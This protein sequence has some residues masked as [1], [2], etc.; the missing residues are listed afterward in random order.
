M[1]KKKLSDKKLW[2][3]YKLKEYVQDKNILSLSR[4]SALLG[5]NKSHV[6]YMF[7]TVLSPYPK[8]EEK[9]AKLAIL[10]D[11]YLSYEGK[12]DFLKKEFLK[13]EN[14]GKASFQ[15]F[16]ANLKY[17]ERI[18]YLKKNPPF[19]INSFEDC[20]EKI[21]KYI[22]P[23]KP[24]LKEKSFEIPTQSPKELTFIPVKNKIAA[25]NEEEKIIKL[26]DENGIYI[27]VTKD[28]ANEKILKIIQLLKDL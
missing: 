5:C 9:R 13:R 18:E 11:E 23:E 28:V 20:I 17:L 10:L 22:H 25:K 19:E 26:L 6:S 15:V 21:K 1:N 3:W 27:T 12:D 8:E 24:T 7:G 4:I 14:I 2:C 16:R